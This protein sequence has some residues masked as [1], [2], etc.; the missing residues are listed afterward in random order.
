MSRP[1]TIFTVSYRILDDSGHT[2]EIVKESGINKNY[3]K[4]LVERKMNHKYGKGKKLQQIKVVE[5][6]P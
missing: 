6:K 5:E 2:L 4:W 3:I 1:R